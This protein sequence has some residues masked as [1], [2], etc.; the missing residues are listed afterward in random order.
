MCRRER[1]RHTS[2]RSSGSSR[3]PTGALAQRAAEFLIADEAPYASTRLPAQLELLA[4]PST[5]VGRRQEMERIVEL[6]ASARGTARPVPCSSPVR[7]VSARAGSSPKWLA[8][9]ADG[10]QVLHGSCFEDVS[11]PYGPFAEAIAG[12]ARDLPAA[13]I[14]RRAGSGGP[15]LSRIVPELAQRAGCR[16]DGRLHHAGEAHVAVDAIVGYLRRSAD[17]AP[18]LLVIEDLHW[19]SDDTRDV[20][21][22]WCELDRRV[23]LW[24]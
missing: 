23:C 12:D 9:H 21:R 4:D 1:S 17:A 3:Q 6:W 8:V 19:S 18:T 24:W 7:P 20:L 22:H 5:L 11:S 10:A 15:A 16:H 2:H 14:R 13:E